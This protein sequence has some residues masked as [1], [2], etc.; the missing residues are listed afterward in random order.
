MYKASIIFSAPML[1][2]VGTIITFAIGGLTGIILVTLGVDVHLHDTYFVVAHFHYTI[3]GGVVFMLFAALHYWF[4]KFVGKM[5]NETKAKIAFAFIFIGFNTLWF[6]MFLAGALG[7]PRRYFDYLP[8][9]T[10][11]H[12]VA[13]IGAFLTVFGIL[14][15][16]YVLYKGIKEGNACGNNP[17]NST[18]LEWQISSPPPLENFKNI[19][20]VD[21]DPYEYE[22]GK[23][24]RDLSKIIQGESNAQ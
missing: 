15:M 20:Y 19:P 14:F 8:E 22:N 13:G 23:P 9:F 12:R 18:T 2:V 21:F 17:W 4:P 1:W 10:I 24:K 5:Y 7:M 6:P 11:Y 16:L 3:F